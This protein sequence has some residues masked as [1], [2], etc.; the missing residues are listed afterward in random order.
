MAIP[1][2][3][4]VSVIVVRILNKIYK[5]WK[6][7]VTGGINPT[8]QRVTASGIRSN[9]N[10][11][12]TVIR[13]R[14]LGRRLFSLGSDRSGRW[15]TTAQLPCFWLRQSSHCLRQHTRKAASSSK[16]AGKFLQNSCC[17]SHTP[18][19][20]RF[21]T[22]SR[23]QSCNVQNTVNRC[24]QRHSWQAPALTHLDDNILHY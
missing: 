12:G 18:L 17:E 11:L 19:R 20:I 14:T 24:R 13:L 15:P 22:L 7:K 1:H 21:A 8:N 2:S 5:F 3:F 23:G 10:F 9:L 6:T 16:V 4:H